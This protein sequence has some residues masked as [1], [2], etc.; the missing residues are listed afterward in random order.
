MELIRT[1]VRFSFFIVLTLPAHVSEIHP[2]D[3]F[4][5][6]IPKSKKKNQNRNSVGIASSGDS[7]NQGVPHFRAFFSHFLFWDNK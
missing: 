3:L 4:T 6:Y 1:L 7:D 2:L 5:F